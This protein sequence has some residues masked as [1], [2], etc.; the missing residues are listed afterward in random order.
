MT[1]GPARY[2]LITRAILSYKGTVT[3]L[4]DCHDS[5][6]ADCHYSEI[7]DCSHETGQLVAAEDSV[8]VY[9]VG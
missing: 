1:R 7:A 2:G 6:I 5:R 8:E 9:D 4:A 3:V